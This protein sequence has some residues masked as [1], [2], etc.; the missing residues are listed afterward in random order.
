MSAQPRL[1]RRDHR[2]GR[3]AP[4]AVLANQAH[5]DPRVSI[6]PGTP[7]DPEALIVVPLIARGQLKGALNIYRARRGRDVQRGRVRA[8][9]ALR[10]RRRARARQRADPRAARAS[11]ADRL[12]DR[13]LQPPRLPRAASARAAA[14]RAAR[15]APSPSLMLDIDDFKRVNDVHGHG[16]GDEVLRAARRVASRVRPRRR[17]R[18]PA[19]RRGVRRDHALVRRRSTPSRSRSGI[20]ERARR[21]SEFPA[22]RR[23]TVS[24][25]L[26]AGPSTR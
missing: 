6:V 13:A 21:R 24:V 14:R 26:A 3:R 23:V 22:G 16:V 18:L 25:G 4:R 19:R 1:R 5:L 15:I 12:A 7:V 10:R 2:L 8:R 11:G 9:A 20:V 17:R